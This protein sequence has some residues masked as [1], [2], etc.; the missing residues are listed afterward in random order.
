MI[1][2]DENKRSLV[3]FLFG[4]CVTDNGPVRSTVVRMD[5][6][7]QLAGSKRCQTRPPEEGSSLVISSRKVDKLPVYL[8]VLHCRGKWMHPQTSECGLALTWWCLVLVFNSKR[9]MLNTNETWHC[10]VRD[11]INGHL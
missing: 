7:Y 5:M 6:S 1:R 2:K 8:Y 4:A 9:V 10:H 3:T 11:I